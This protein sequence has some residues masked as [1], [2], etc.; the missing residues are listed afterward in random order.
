MSTY[1]PIKTLNAYAKSIG[2]RRGKG[3]YNGSPFWLRG[4]A[5][6]THYELCMFYCGFGD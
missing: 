5:I 1:P 4:N 6:V 3:T 2:L